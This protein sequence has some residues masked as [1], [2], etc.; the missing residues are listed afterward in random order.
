MKWH[1]LYKRVSDKGGKDAIFLQPTLTGLPLPLQ[2]YDE[3]FLPYSRDIIQATKHQVNIYIFDLASYFRTGAAG[4]V[5][6]ERA[7]AYVRNE[8]VTILHGPFVGTQY[9]C[10]GGDASLQVDALTVLFKRDLDYYLD[11]PP[12][13]AFLWTQNQE[14]VA[15]GGVLTSNQLKLYYD[16]EE[17]SLNLITNDLLLAD[18]TDNYIDTIREQLTR[19]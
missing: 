17:L 5:A 13:S 16:S 9:E 1:E 7:I 8:A 4:I 11:H 12:Y 19:R 14:T 3:P 2:R 10:L 18:K 15:N 6:L